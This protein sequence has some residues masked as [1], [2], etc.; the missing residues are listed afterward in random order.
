[1]RSAYYEETYALNADP[2]SVIDPAAN[3][4][5][6][7]YDRCATLLTAYSHVGDPAMLRHALRA[8]SYYSARITLD[9]P[10]RG[11]FT[12]KPTADPKYSHTRGLYAY[13]ALTGDEGALASITAM[14]KMWEVEPYFVASYRAGSIRGA[15][16]VWTERLLGTSLE[17]LFYGFQATG[18]KALLTA[19][20]QLLDTAYRH[21]TTTDQATL[22][23]INKDPN[24]P[25]FPP[26]GCW[27]HNAVQAAES[28]GATPTALPWCSGWMSELVIDSL[29]AYQRM[30]DDPRVD[31]IF[32]QLAR[33]LRDVG[34]AYMNAN[35]LQ[36][37]FLAPSAPYP[38]RLDQ[39]RHLIPLYGAGVLSDGTRV[40]QGFSSDEEHCTDATALTAAALRALVRQGTYDA[41]GP[42]GPFPSEG[43]A[44]LALHHEFAFC[45]A[46]VFKQWDRSGRDPAR[47][48]SAFL[49]SIMSAAG[50][51]SAAAIAKYGVG[52][53]SHPS[54]PQRKL[55]WWFNTS[56]L[57]FALLREAGI[58]IPVLKPGS[59]QPKG[60]PGPARS[61]LP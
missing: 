14:A 4:E 19:F 53:P 26:Q 3:Y 54:Y 9:G 42:I 61:W 22:V 57:Q 37:S 20:T 13:Y 33:F 7:L 59:V 47:V 49:A 55:S 40:A 43:A 34:S 28:S 5:G 6:W 1:V 32:L 38:G 52:F 30:T 39:V 11:I 18:D 24:S 56:M 17:G 51:D 21:I 8:C 48:T 35:P 45:S 25:P 44:L 2:T 12:G 27:I 46:W 36:D 23:A 31:E 58:K 41:G 60:K 16:A 15:T 29:L 50:G 10:T